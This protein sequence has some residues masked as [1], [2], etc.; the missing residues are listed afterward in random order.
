MS[1]VMSLTYLHSA[2]AGVS[3][4]RTNLV[5]DFAPPGLEIVRGITYIGIIEADY[6]PG[7][8]FRAC[9]AR[10]SSARLKVNIILCTSY[11]C[12]RTELTIVYYV[13]GIKL[14]LLILHPSLYIVH[15]IQS[16]YRCSSE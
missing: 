14:W 9:A 11:L 7:L 16:K 12:C 5:H 3:S 4:R 13:V 2:P 8:P 10:L 1:F 6:V 15:R